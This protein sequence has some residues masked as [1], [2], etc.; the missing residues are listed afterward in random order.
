MKWKR[1]LVVCVSIAGAH[2][3]KIKGLRSKALT[4]AVW[5]LHVLGYSAQ[6]FALKTA[7]FQASQNMC[8]TLF[9]RETFPSV[10]WA[11]FSFLWQ[12][13][14]IEDVERILD[15]TQES[16]EYQRVNACSVSELSLLFTIYK[17]YTL[18]HYY[19]ILIYMVTYMCILAL[20]SD[21]LYAFTQGQL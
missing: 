18:K 3:L 11:S 6:I 20:S 19:I 4:T 13:M 17:K 21:G 5:L 16:I 15:E 1:E 10:T 9:I 12:M 14:S 7:N 8:K 2:C